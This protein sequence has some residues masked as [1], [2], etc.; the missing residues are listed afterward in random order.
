[1]RRTL[2]A[3]ILFFAGS[4]AAAIPPDLAKLTEDIERFPAS[5]GTAA[6]NVRLEKFFDLF[7]AARMREFP[8][9][10]AYIGYPGLDDRLP[11]FS[12]EM[13]ALEHRLPH[14]ELAAMNSIDRSRLTPSD[15][16]NYDLARR[17]FEMEIEG[18]VFTASIRSTTT[19][20]SSTR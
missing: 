15:Q 18:S 13:L 5:K 4:A 2:A 20:S 10:A 14:L 6:E 12:P 1:M 8:E 17:R 3:F 16:L 19:T 11:D 7:W 9:L